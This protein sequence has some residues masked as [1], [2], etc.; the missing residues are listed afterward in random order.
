MPEN[1]IIENEYDRL[2]VSGQRQG[3]RSES[4]REVSPLSQRAVCQNEPM[5]PLEQHQLV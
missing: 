4:E 1:L 2:S 5:A 3:F